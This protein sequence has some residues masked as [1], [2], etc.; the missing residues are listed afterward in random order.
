M[1]SKSSEGRLAS[2]IENQSVTRLEC[3][4]AYDR[5]NSRG[6]DLW[7]T[8]CTLQRQ[9]EE[10]LGLLQSLGAYLHVPDWQVEG[11]C[12]IE[13]NFLDTWAAVVLHTKISTTVNNI[14]NFSNRSYEKKCGIKETTSNTRAI[15]AL[16]TPR[17]AHR[18]HVIAHF[19]FIEASTLQEG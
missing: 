12:P 15:P 5:I 9:G 8:R 17:P 11:K 2:H 19:Y 10:R 14:A 16:S 3:L 1:K 6:G 4:I 18:E 13:I 7:R